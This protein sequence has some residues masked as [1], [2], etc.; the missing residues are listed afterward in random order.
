MG[1]DCHLLGVLRD[2]REKIGKSI[3]DEVHVTVE[4]DDEPRVVDVPADF[5]A[6][7]AEQPAAGQFFDRLGYTH[8]RE[9]VQW[10]VEAKRDQTRVS[11]IEK[12]VQMLLREKRQR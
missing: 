3:G 12:A 1:G 10:I 8:Q 2:I 4:N 11:R 5:R 7:L 6:A 9:Y